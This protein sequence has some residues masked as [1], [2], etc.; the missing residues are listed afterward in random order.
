M[1]DP[2]I[3]EPPGIAI[4]LGAQIHAAVTESGLTQ[5]ELCQL[6]GGTSEKHLSQVITGRTAASLTLLDAIAQALGH[7]W[8]VDLVPAGNPTE[9][10]FA[11]LRE[12]QVEASNPS[13]RLIGSRSGVSHETAAQMLRGDKV[14]TWTTLRRVV[15]DGLGG[16]EAEFQALWRRAAM[17]EPGGPRV[18]RE[19]A[20]TSRSSTRDALLKL[21]KEVSALREEIRELRGRGAASHDA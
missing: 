2:A 8:V 4:C 13:T 3:G 16:S 20:I 12:L 9:E 21:A 7:H 15:V 5:K 17:T 6:L 10:L 14:P 11:R 1:T 18:G 19:K